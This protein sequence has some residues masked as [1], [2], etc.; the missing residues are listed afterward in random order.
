M[1]Y[2]IF[3]VVDAVFPMISPATYFAL[4]TAVV[5]TV[6]VPAGD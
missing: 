1:T 6:V 3:S 2:T 4:E 5:W